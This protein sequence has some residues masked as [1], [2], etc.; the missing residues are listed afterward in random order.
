MADDG[1][2]S[3]TERRASMSELLNEIRILL[4]GTQL[5]L[6]LL[7]IL[8]FQARFDKLGSTQLHVYAATVLTTILALAFF[9][10]PAAYHRI[11]W[12]VHHRD[13]FKAFANWFLIAGLVPFSLGVVLT[14]YLV[15]SVVYPSLALATTI[16][17]AAILA[18]LWWVIPLA[19]A[20]DWY[21]RRLERQGRPVET[22]PAT[23]TS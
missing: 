21:R 19:R 20:H 18:V 6:S 11:A 4:P 22:E 3:D 15:T 9:V 8:P 12:P 13:S 7:L 23:G 14:T 2:S 10:A 16:G 1:R 5:F 17:V